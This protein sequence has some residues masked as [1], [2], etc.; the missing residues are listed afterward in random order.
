VKQQKGLTIVKEGIK[1]ENSQEEFENAP[2]EKEEITKEDIG[3]AEDVL[4]EDFFK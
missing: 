2:K 3:K 4:G 1:M